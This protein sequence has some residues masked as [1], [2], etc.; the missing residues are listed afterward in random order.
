MI[1]L[2]TVTGFFASKI[3]PWKLVGVGFGVL[4]ILAVVGGG[5]VK[6]WRWC[7]G[8]GGWWEWQ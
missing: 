3:I 1:G 7:S 5:G 8:G 2:A 6:W 4:A